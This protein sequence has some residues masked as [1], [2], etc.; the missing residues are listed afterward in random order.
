MTFAQLRST[1]QS[2]VNM[3][4]LRR[5]LCS[6]PVH[7]SAPPEP[8]D[9][10]E[11]ARIKISMNISVS[12]LLVRYLQRLGID[13]LFG[14][15]G[16]HVLPIYDCLRDS[17]VKSVLVKHEQGAAFMAGGYARVSHQ[18]SACIATAGPGAT[19]LITGIA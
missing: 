18:P 5:V 19:N 2:G 11:T 12:E 6:N 3:V 13:T 9:W 17:S 16:A 14:M 4:S 7:P 10:S 15:P 1:R 8:P